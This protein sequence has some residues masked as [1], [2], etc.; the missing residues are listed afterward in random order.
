M[1]KPRKLVRLFAM[2]LTLW[3]L[4]GTDIPGATRSMDGT[5]EL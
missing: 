5:S 1:N 2:T 4:P 3:L